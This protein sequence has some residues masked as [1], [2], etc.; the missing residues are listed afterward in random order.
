[1]ENLLEKPFEN[2][3]PYELDNSSSVPLY[4]QI[5]RFFLVAI[6]TGKLRVGEKL[7]TEKEICEQFGVSRITARRAVLELEEMGHVERKQGKGTFIIDRQ[8]KV[9]AMA[10]HGFGGFAAH[11]SGVSDTKIISKRFGM[12]SEKEAA[13]LNV[14]IGSP[15]QELVRCLYLDGMPLMLD[16]ALYSNT[17]Y[18][19]LIDSYKKGES[20]YEIL[21]KQYHTT[22]FTNEKEI[23]YTVARPDE[24]IILKCNV[25]DPLYYIEKSVLDENGEVIHHAISLAVASRVKLTLSYSRK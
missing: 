4:S 11:S 20:T 8:V 19:G 24:A 25:G 2:L 23:S 22:A 3:T 9:Y 10:M 6:S 18:P 15:V 16:R 5:V 21:A 7:P 1:M 12:A 13:W 17:K 14:D